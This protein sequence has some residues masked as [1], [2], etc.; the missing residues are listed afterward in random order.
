M[1]KSE[2]LI[3]RR[4]AIVPEGMGMYSPLTI[5]SGK[6]AT[7]TD[8]DGREY[9]DFAGGIGV[10]NAGH[11]PKSVVDAIVNQSKQFVHACFPVAIYEPYVALCEELARIFP[12]GKSTKV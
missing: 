9:I 12:H 4:N 2:K 1:K 3:A 10:L 8:L 5:S 6:G 11:C 7:I